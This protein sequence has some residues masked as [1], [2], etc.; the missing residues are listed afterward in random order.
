MYDGEDSQQLPLGAGDSEEQ[1]MTRVATKPRASQRTS[2]FGLADYTDCTTEQAKQDFLDERERGGG[3]SD[4]GQ[5]KGRLIKII[6]TSPDMVAFLRAVGDWR[7]E[8]PDGVARVEGLK[9]GYLRYLDAYEPT[10]HVATTPKSVYFG[11]L[12][13]LV[14][15][16][17]WVETRYG[18]R[19]VLRLFCRKD[20]LSQRGFK[21][22]ARLVAMTH[23]HDTLQSGILDVWTGEV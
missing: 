7:D 12:T 10:V 16:E 9:N 15:P 6:R 4:T 11:R 20:K 23:P 2:L 3:P 22:A 8:D 19:Q 17:I 1:C 13:V 18:E 21:V 5:A 14:Q